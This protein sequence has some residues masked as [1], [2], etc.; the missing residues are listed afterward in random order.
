MNN[1]LKENRSTKLIML[2]PLFFVLMP[3]PEIPGVQ[4][5]TYPLIAVIFGLISLTLIIKNG[6]HKTTSLPLSLLSAL[7]VCICLSILFNSSGLSSLPHLAKI[8]LFIVVF[9]FGDLVG[10]VKNKDQIFKGL[11]KTA[12]IVLTVQ[13]IVG[14]TQLLGNP[15]FSWIYSMDKTRPWG[16]MVRIA[17]TLDNPNIFAWIVIQMA[18]LV[19]LLEPKKFNKVFWVFLCFVLV[20]LSGSRSFLM[21]YPAVMILIFVLSSKKSA[22]FM[23][24]K[25]PMFLT[26]IGALIAIGYR[27]LVNNAMSFPYLSQLLY[28]FE[29]GSLDSVHSFNVRT[30]MW[31]DALNQM[32]GTVT[33]LFGLGPG[34]I[35]VLD[36][37]YLYSTVNYGLIFTA[38]NLLMYLVFLIYFFKCKDRILMT[39]GV[40]YIVFSLVVGY[41]ADA[42]SGWNYPLLIMFYTGIAVA[43]RRKKLKNKKDI[44]Q[45]NKTQKLEAV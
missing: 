6:L 29:T 16:G 19:F 21:I 10:L 43:L 13:I 4:F 9:L 17:G 35:E 37:D 38:V 7:L 33:W 45:E 31:Q 11:L 22:V 2:F 25:L 5:L 18:V 41:Q 30:L 27:F 24:V 36:N 34:S 39:L 28:I 44:A 14:I 32:N 26:T 8:F 42:L 23:F 40:Q 1:I 3:R 20:F 12:Y 15:V